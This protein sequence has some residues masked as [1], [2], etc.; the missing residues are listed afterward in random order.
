[1]TTST[2]WCRAIAG[3]LLL[4]AAPA[5][6]GRLEPVARVSVAA[7]SLSLPYPGRARLETTW[8][9]KV[10]LERLGSP[11]VVFVH[12]LDAGG[13]VVRTFD[14]LFPGTWSEGPPLSDS[15]ALWQSALAP[16]L[17]P[18]S[19]QL[20]FGLYDVHNQRRWPL[21]VDGVEVDDD[22]YI[23]AT[24]EVPPVR[25]SAPAVSYSGSWGPP[26]PIG[27]RQLVAHRWLSGSGRLEVSGLAGPIV[28][29]LRLAVPA[30][31]AEGTRLVVDEPGAAA[32]LTVRSD[33]APDTWTVAPGQQRD[34][35]LT[36]RPPAGASGCA[37]DLTPNFAFVDLKSLARRA[38]SLDLLTWN[39]VAG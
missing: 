38:A 21:T 26:E 30:A 3:A 20:S 17:P 31:D 34:L 7:T 14:H 6:R 29:G 2:R 27:D 4:L 36:L 22:E 5:C 16:A 28:L 10:P 37:V 25:T 13:K 11:P 18:G 8:E 32:T 9:A 1:M 12:L 15:I 33:C 35:E 24:V 23:V 39:E 19:Y